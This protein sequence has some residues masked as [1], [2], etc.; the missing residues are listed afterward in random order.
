MGVELLR[1]EK[2]LDILSFV[3]LFQED[4]KELFLVAVGCLA[5]GTV[6]VVEFVNKGSE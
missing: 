2:G 1:C 5:R 3:V 4:G 6:F